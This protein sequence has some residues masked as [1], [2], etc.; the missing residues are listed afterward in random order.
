M[1]RMDENSVL[2]CGVWVHVLVPHPIPSP[3]L[4]LF[5]HLPFLPSFPTPPHV[6]HVPRSLHPH[7]VHPLPGS[8]PALLWIHPSLRLSTRQ[9]VNA[10]KLTGEKAAPA[11]LTGSDGLSRVTQSGS[12]VQ[13]LTLLSSF[14]SHLSFTLH[15]HTPSPLSL[16]E[17]TRTHTAHSY[18]LSLTSLS[19][20]HH[21]SISFALCTAVRDATDFCKNALD[22]ETIVLHTVS[23]RTLCLLAHCC[24]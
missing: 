16:L 24:S 13:I 21:L 10:L 12:A 18:S 17:S 19:L 23:K 7:M 4:S 8:Q 9:P 3:H 5:T 14:P 11:T 1:E 2:V 22:P 15:T 20:A 6:P